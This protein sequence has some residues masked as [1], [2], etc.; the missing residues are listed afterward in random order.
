MSEHYSAWPVRVKKGDRFQLDDG[1]WFYAMRACTIPSKAS[2]E[3]F[4]KVGWIVPLR[5]D[6]RAL[7]ISLDEYAKRKM[8]NP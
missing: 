1:R 8:E 2:V 3:T 6:G 7:A 5:A 4:E